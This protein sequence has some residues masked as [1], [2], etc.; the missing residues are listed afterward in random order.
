MNTLQNSGLL[1]HVLGFVGG[2]ATA[3]GLFDPALGGAIST[4]L[5]AAGPL[6]GAAV[7]LWSFFAPEKKAA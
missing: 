7:T 4:V 1:R 6:V 3:V 5:A 2:A